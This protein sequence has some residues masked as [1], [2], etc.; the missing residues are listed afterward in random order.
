[1]STDYLWISLI[2]TISEQVVFSKNGKNLSGFLPQTYFT[3]IYVTTGMHRNV[4]HLQWLTGFW[5][6][7]HSIHEMPFPT[8]GPLELSHYL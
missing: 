6:R 8:D 7:D 2:A 5:S 3:G 4:T 1:M